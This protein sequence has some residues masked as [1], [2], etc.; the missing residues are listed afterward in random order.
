MFKS[1]EKTALQEIG[2]RFTLRL[3][4]IRNGIP[5]NNALG[6]PIKPLEITQDERGEDETIQDSSAEKAK[7]SQPR[8]K[9]PADGEYA[10]S[11][12]VSVFPLPGPSSAAENIFDQSPS[13]SSTS[14]RSSY[15]GN[16]V[17]IHD[18]EW[19]CCVWLMLL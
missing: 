7:A 2:P 17:F 13:S 16:I 4:S 8:G 15:D 10:W 1:T 18:D 19:G 11:W 6:A 9:K 5:Q 3:R 14:G 12:N